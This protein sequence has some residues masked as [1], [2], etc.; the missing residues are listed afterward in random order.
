[1]SEKNLVSILDTEARYAVQI[2]D[3]ATH[4]TFNVSMR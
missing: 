2:N 4:I 3:A 1:M